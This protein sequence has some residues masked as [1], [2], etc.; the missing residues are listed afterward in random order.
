MVSYRALQCG[1]HKIHYIRGPKSAPLHRIIACSKKYPCTVLYKTVDHQ[2]I[3]YAGN[4]PS[5]Y[6]KHHAMHLISMQEPLFY[7]YS[8]T[9]TYVVFC[10]LIGCTNNRSIINANVVPTDIITLLCRC[11]RCILSNIDMLFATKGIEKL[12]MNT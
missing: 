2:N 12:L 11:I 4:K 8:N 5:Y 3:P 9:C 1:P 6:C 7:Q 10:R